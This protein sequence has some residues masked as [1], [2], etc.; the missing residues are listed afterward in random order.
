MVRYY[1]LEQKYKNNMIKDSIEIRL[2]APVI[3]T[4]LNRYDHFVACLESL[5]RCTGAQY[6]DVYVGLDYP[7]SEKYME[8]WKKIDIYLRQKELSNSFKK[9]IVFRRDKNCGVGNSK[10]N[11]MLLFQY[12]MEHYDSFIATEDD[13]I[14]SENFLEFENKGLQKFKDDETIL[15]ICGYCHPYRFKCLGNNYFFHQTDFSAWGYATWTD[16]YKKTFSEIQGG[17]IKN[18]L[19]LKKIFM[20][21]KYGYNRLFTFL[22]TAMHK[23]WIRMM[24]SVLAV[25]IQLKN[26]KVVVPTVTKVRNIGWDEAGQSF[27]NGMPKKYKEIAKRHKSQQIDILPYFNYEGDP[28]TYFDDNNLIAVDESDG[29]ISF[30]QFCIDVFSV[31]LIWI[32]RRI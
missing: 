27:L 31:L 25:Y 21:K 13:N 11:S 22:L 24:D 30:F 20:I 5:E 3:I 18:S 6:T 14:F 32:K 10:S 8:G 2:Y 26:Y 28:M 4:T 15:A 9:L 19:S 17:F 12:I 16:K 7:P 1:R 29:K 23:G